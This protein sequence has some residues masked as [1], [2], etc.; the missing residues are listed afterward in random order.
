MGSTFLLSVAA[1]AQAVT[2]PNL[3]TL[4]LGLVTIM[5][6]SAVVVGLILRGFI[7]KYG[8]SYITKLIETWSTSEAVK[9]KRSN[10][11]LD[12]VTRWYTS[13]PIRED[14]KK[15]TKDVV[16]NETRRD[17]GIIRKEIESSI[18][19]NTQAVSKQLNEM[20]NKLEQNTTLFGQIAQRLSHIEG[21]VDVVKNALKFSSGVSQQMSKVTPPKNP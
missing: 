18:E 2:I 20:L 7:S 19:S 17:D 12:T 9:T 10:D 5:G 13:D 6:G 21:S 1:E 4:L 15:F 16:E 3:G 11:V 14:R 8:D